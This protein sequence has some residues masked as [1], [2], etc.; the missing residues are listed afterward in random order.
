MADRRPLQSLVLC[1]AGEKV[2]SAL[3]SAR[4]MYELVTDVAPAGFCPGARAEVGPEPQAMTACCTWPTRGETGLHDANTM[5]PAAKCG[6]R[7]RSAH[8]PAR[9][10]LAVSPL[11]EP[12]ADGEARADK[13]ESSEQCVRLAHGALEAVEP[14][15][16]PHRQYLCRLL[17]V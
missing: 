16:R 3:A 8:S 4:L 10:C 12:G 9:W 1:E 14:G 15:V 7:W 17:G 2:R 5:T 6:W 11:R 13:V